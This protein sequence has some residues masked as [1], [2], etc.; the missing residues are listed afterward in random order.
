MEINSNKNQFCKKNDLI[1]QFIKIFLYMIKNIFLNWFSM[2][3]D[4]L[5][6]EAKENDAKFLWELRNEY[7][8][9]LMS[10]STE[11]IDWETHEEW[12]L[13]I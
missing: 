5:I 6:S 7:S 2:L 4:L 11:L 3:K 9:R 8:I 1:L 12:F 10:K 13:N